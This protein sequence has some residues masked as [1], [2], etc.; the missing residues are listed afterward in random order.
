MLC[1]GRT[2]QQQAHAGAVVDL[3]AC[4]AGH[5]IA[6]AAAEL[7]AQLGTI[8]LNDGTDVV[9]HARRVVDIGEELVQFPFTLHAPDG[10]NSI[11][12]RLKGIG[13]GA[14]G[15][16]STGQALHGDKAHICRLALV[17]Q[18]Q[19]LLTGDIA[20]RELQRLVQTAVNGLVGHLQA[21]V[22][23]AD[24]PDHALGFGLLH[25]LVEAG[26]VAW[27]RAECGIMELVQVNVIGAQIG[28]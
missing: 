11:E 16:Q 1:R 19:L 4:R 23:D 8:P 3:D 14:V 26:A 12:L 7:A 17:H 6:A 28:E 18:F 10:Q 15:D 2:T 24:M 21:V 13:C 5:T 9:G 27:L 25:S 22:G 20:E